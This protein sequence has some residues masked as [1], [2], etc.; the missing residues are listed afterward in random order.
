M[1]TNSS[2]MICLQLCVLFNFQIFVTIR[3]VCVIGNSKLDYF[4][5]G[6]CRHE[7]VYSF[8]KMISSCLIRRNWFWMFSKVFSSECFFLLV[9]KVAQNSFQYFPRRKFWWFL[10]TTRYHFMLQS[11]YQK[12]AQSSVNTLVSFSWHNRL[13]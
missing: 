10:I 12:I 5:V 7:S 9:F 6:D 8:V 13:P 11:W 1:F 4:I 3:P 2:E